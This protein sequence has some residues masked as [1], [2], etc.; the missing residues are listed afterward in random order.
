MIILQIIVYHSKFFELNTM[1]ELLTA[2]Q[3]QETLK[4]DRTTIYRMLKD[5]RL[6]GFKV[7]GQWRFPKNE[8]DELL[9]FRG[10]QDLTP[11]PAKHILPLR[12]LQ[13][14]QDV[15]AEI[16]EVGSI[17]LDLN[18]VALTRLSNNC[19]FCQM[20]LS[21]EKGR[22]ACQTTWKN[23]VLKDHEEGGYKTCHAGL[24]YTV[25][26]ISVE[27]SIIAKLVAGQFFDK[28]NS[29]ESGTITVKKMADQFGLDRRKL[30][31]A[32]QKVP[33]LD[34]QRQKQICTWITKV[35]R[36]FGD[37]GKERAELI[38]K[39]RNIAEISTLSSADY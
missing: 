18:G 13:T 11:I 10:N 20:I 15:F 36:S 34:H 33:A 25:S 6:S 19:E 3:V 32:V 7:G 12:C 14:I 17:T 26:P 28:K 23:L 31:D 27:G 35:S 9:H 1:D 2:R 37:I 30:Q 29:S 24:L 22:A 39:L 4:I 5:G 16:A 38:Q 21:S 8:I